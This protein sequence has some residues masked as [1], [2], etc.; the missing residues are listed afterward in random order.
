MN[1]DLLEG[2]H[3]KLGALV[4]W[5][6]FGAALF[7]MA[8]FFQKSPAVPS[9][10]LL[11]LPLVIGTGFLFTR[12]SFFSSALAAVFVFTFFAAILIV[13]EV[14]KIDFN[15]DFPDVVF[16]EPLKS[17]AV[18][19]L[20]VFVCLFLAL[21]LWQ[22]PAGWDWE[23]ASPSEKGFAKATWW[24]FLLTALILGAL[25]SQGDLITQSAYHSAEWKSHQWETYAGLD[26]L[27]TMLGICALSAT[28]RAY[29]Q[30]HRLFYFTLIVLLGAILYFKLL[31]GQRS[32]AFGFMIFLALLYYTLSKSKWKGWVIVSMI[33][34]AFVFLIAWAS[35][36]GEASE[37]GLGRALFESSS[38]TLRDIQEGSVTRLDRFPK[39]TWDMLETT[40]LY[41]S[42]IRRNGQT[43]LNLIPQT[44]PSFV[45][46]LIDYERPLTEPWVLAHYFPHGGGIFMVAEAYWN[47]GLAGVVGLALILGWI[48]IG[49][50]RFYRALPPVFTYGYYGAVVISAENVLVGI[51]SF[52][53]GLEIALLITG[54]GW[55][56][57]R[58]L[59]RGSAGVRNG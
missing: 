43:Y 14:V 30:R 28:L 25:T 5:T 13:T 41:E 54:I 56:L 59:I 48:C 51:Q 12:K 11:T 46:E 42:G 58:I 33:P 10:A 49:A 53:R 40:F 20:L 23:E 37:V 16:C 32:T 2:R 9:E 26:A 47:F 19:A 50:E 36:R 22:A 31:R 18:H 38:S 17:Q 34:A 4:M 45:A 29:G 7:G 21:L 57:Y 55:V 8:A 1:L 24:F 27:W 3:G 52:V 15:I 39:I 35:V 6:L 44:V